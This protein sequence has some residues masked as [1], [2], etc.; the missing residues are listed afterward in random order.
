ME[1]HHGNALE[2]SER[3]DAPVGHDNGDIDLDILE[4]AEIDGDLETELNGRFLDR[5]GC[6]RSPTTPTSIGPRDHKW[7]LESGGVNR[8]QR[9]NR[10][11]GST[12]KGNAG[13]GVS[14]T[15]DWLGHRVR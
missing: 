9:G 2:Q 6:E 13:E 4:R 3:D 7:N 1:V 14:G 5:T 10:D 11:I 12:Q 15:S 8:P